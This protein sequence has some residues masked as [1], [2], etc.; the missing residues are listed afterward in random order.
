L[1]L[2]I[3]ASVDDRARNASAKGLVARHDRLL[4]SVVPLGS[5]RG[6]LLPLRLQSSGLLVLRPDAGSYPSGLPV[7]VGLKAKE[8]IHFLRA[9]NALVKRALRVGLRRS[10]HRR[11]QRTSSTSRSQ[12]ERL[13][14]CA[15]CTRLLGTVRGRLEGADSVGPEG[16]DASSV[17]Q[18]T[19]ASVAIIDE[20][21][22]GI[23]PVTDAIA[24]LRVALRAGEGSVVTVLQAGPLA[25][26]LE[27][28]E[29]LVNPG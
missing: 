19:S 25:L 15:F 26:L 20:A 2:R 23:A 29:P 6:S 24:T 14:L 17:I 12:T 3:E 27:L 21:S 8:L 18:H 22:I 9:D 11:S 28:A 13:P 16:L 10:R 4:L 5:C 1:A 7:G